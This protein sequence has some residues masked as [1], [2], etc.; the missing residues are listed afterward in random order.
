MANLSE[1]IKDQF[2]DQIIKAHEN[3]KNAYEIWLDSP[4]ALNG[5]QYIKYVYDQ[6]AILPKISL[7][8]EKQYPW[9]EGKLTIHVVDQI[10]REVIEMAYYY[11][12]L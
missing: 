1:S 3:R 10:A 11:G 7:A 2:R 9:I 5:S 8:L 4:T 12:E 6:Q